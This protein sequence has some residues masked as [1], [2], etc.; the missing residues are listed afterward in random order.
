M[1]LEIMHWSKLI[2]LIRSEEKQN[3]Y[4]FL[5]CLVPSGNAL[6]LFRQ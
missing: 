6:Q 5:D 1:Q 3:I 4:P 2:L